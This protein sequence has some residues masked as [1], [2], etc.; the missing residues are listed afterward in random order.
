MFQYLVLTSNDP[1]L[2]LEL[3]LQPLP[4]LNS[5]FSFPSTYF[6]LETPPVLLPDILLFYVCYPLVSYILISYFLDKKL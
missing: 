4:S 6:G 1:K 3:Y 5:Y 2:N